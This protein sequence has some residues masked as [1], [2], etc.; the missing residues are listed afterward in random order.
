[1]LSNNTFLETCQYLSADAILA[2]AQ[3]NKEQRDI[4]SSGNFWK[5]LVLFKYKI[6][7]EASI[8]AKDYDHLDSIFRI[9]PVELPH[10]DPSPLENHEKLLEER[11]EETTL[12]NKVF[13]HMRDKEIKA[14]QEDKPI[15]LFLMSPYEGGALKGAVFKAHSEEGAIYK[16]QSASH[17]S[18]IYI[19]TPMVD[20]IVDMK[21][22]EMTPE[23][24]S[25]CLVE[26]FIDPG[27]GDF[28]LIEI[29]KITYY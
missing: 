28:H 19:Y 3:T 13:E 29:P 24:H 2:F 6:T 4:I 20:L 15:R 8:G 18:G 22:G 25:N 26:A 16:L 5:D 27:D 1:M 11:K 14:W 23:D 12:V 9:D 21:S 17:K 10:P 7:R